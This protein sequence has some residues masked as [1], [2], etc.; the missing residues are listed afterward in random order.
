MADRFTT[1]AYQIF[2]T[3]A[4]RMFE[5]LGNHRD[6]STYNDILRKL[7]RQA[8]VKGTYGVV[9]ESRRSGE[10]FDG[11]RWMTEYAPVAFL[12]AAEETLQ[13]PFELEN[14]DG[15]RKIIFKDVNTLSIDRR[16]LNNYLREMYDDYF[17]KCIE[18]NM[19]RQS[20]GMSVQ[21]LPHLDHKSDSIRLQKN[22]ETEACRPY[23]EAFCETRVVRDK[24][25]DESFELDTRK[26]DTEV[27]RS[28]TVVF[29]VFNVDNRRIEIKDSV[30]N[31]SDINQQ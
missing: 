16:Q 13:P 1:K 25:G 26:L 11:D 12:R 3:E 9:E 14:V 15:D 7:W 6:E 27:M 20:S 23:L 19:R 4:E 18:E 24:N 28:I 31:R 21:V 10:I 5:V 29:N 2:R 22:R 30:I 17:R 8:L